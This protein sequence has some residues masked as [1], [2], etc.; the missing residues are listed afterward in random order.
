[1][2]ILALRARKAT[3]AR[4]ELPGQRDRRDQLEIQARLA[5]KDLRVQ[6]A[7]CPDRPER[8]GQQ[9]RRDQKVMPDHRA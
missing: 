9:V 6:I 7:R 3:P 1:L 2:E 8:Q 5:R 4:R